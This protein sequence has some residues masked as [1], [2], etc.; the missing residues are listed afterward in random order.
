MRLFDKLRVFL[1]CI[2]INK[3]YFSVTLNETL[4][5]H[6]VYFYRCNWNFSTL[7]DLNN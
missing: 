2:L 4:Q 7:G 3:V 1:V 5:L 6:R